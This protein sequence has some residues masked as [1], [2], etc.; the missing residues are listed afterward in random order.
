MTTAE[1][2]GYISAL[3]DI[4]VELEEAYIEGGG[5]V[6]D[7]TAALEAR[8]D[9]IRELLEGDGIDSLG[10]WLKA[11]EDRVAAIKAEKDALARQQKAAERTVEYI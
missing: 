2:K 8:A 10:R 6:T 3:T 7:E 9:A 11:Q 1:I 5:E 4:S